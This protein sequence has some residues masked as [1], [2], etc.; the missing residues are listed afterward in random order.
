[1]ESTQLPEVT[2]DRGRRLELFLADMSA[3]GPV[4]DRINAS[5]SKAFKQGCF[6]VRNSLIVG[7]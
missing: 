3:F 5:F 7:L 6:Q 1:M 2:L 4:Q